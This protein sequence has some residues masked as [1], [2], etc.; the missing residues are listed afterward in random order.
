MPVNEQ[1]DQQNDEKNPRLVLFDGGGLGEVR[2]SSFVAVILALLA[3]LPVTV[4]LVVLG[5][6]VV[7]V[8]D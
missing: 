5:F 1:N 3:V 7:D 6:T 2:L 8:A 4:D